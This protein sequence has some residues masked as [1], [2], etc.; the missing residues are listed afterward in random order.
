M[1]GSFEGDLIRPLGLLTL[2]FGYAEA[3]VN[4]LLDILRSGGLPV[5]VPA[6]APLGQRVL[7]FVAAVKPL[8]CAGAVEVVTI[9]EESKSLIDHRNSLVHAS[10]LAKGHVVPN[11]PS[12]S[13]FTVTP[14]RITSL[15]DQVFTWK[16][17]LNA[18]VQLRLVPALR[19]RS[20]NG[21]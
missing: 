16:E 12:K 9:L 1:S 10:V 20:S 2:N 17:R 3:Q 4:F 15:A 18:A 7:A 6:T 11:D 14:E 8:K 21:T 5:D 19:Q 13:S